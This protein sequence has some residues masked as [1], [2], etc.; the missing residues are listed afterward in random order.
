[1]RRIF[2]AVLVLAVGLVMPATHAATRD[3]VRIISSTYLPGHLRAR[4][5]RSVTWKNRDGVNHTATSDIGGFFNTGTIASETQTTRTIFAAGAFPYHCSFHSSMHGTVRARFGLSTSSTTAGT[6][7]TLIAASSTAPSGFV[8]DYA[9]KVRSRAWKIFKT[10][11]TNQQI[12]FTPSKAGTFR[13]RSRVYNTNG[14]PS[15][16]APAAKLAVAS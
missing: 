16:W 9:K 15:G 11:I 14:K 2:A 4:V 12:T 7:L 8:Y 6:A 5:G 13:F 10:K 3:S 1:M